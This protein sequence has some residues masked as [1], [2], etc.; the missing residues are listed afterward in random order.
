MTDEGADTKCLRCN[1][2]FTSAKTLKTHQLEK[3]T[4]A[5]VKCFKCG[6]RFTTQDRFRVHWNNKHVTVP[7][8]PTE[9]K[10]SSVSDFIFLYHFIGKKIF[11]F[12][13][14]FISNTKTRTSLNL[15]FI[16]KQ[17]VIEWENG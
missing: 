10:P 1:L 3:H 17:T 4:Q 12:G 7:K 8:T 5:G 13:D 9:P 2:N 11:A 6:L 14:Q 15:I 16:L